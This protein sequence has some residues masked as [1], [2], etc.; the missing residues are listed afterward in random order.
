MIFWVAFGSIAVIGFH[1]LLK[2]F[3]HG[4][5]DLATSLHLVR[6]LQHVISG[7][8]I[9]ALHHFVQH[10]LGLIMV[11][12][13][14]V[15]F[16]IFDILRRKYIP[17]LNKW[18]ISHWETLLRPHEIY[19]SPPAAF[20]FLAG[21]TCTFFLTQVRPITE[22]SVLFLSCCDPAASIFGILIGG[23]KIAP[24][25]TLAGTCAAGLVGMLCS[26]YIGYLHSIPYLWLYGF[27]VA[28][29]SELISVPYLDD[30]LTI[31]VFTCMSFQLLS[32]LDLIKFPL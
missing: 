9:L 30:N 20:F 19:D 10:Q 2:V 22:L 21:I 3:L 1:V 29:F 7:F 28:I 13:P 18:F 17:E 11:L 31:P 25:K 27:P 12:V 16:F 26:L 14:T 6:R 8:I 5:G 4:K 15:F 24:K 23:I 32:K